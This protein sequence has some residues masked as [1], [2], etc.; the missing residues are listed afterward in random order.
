[1]SQPTITWDIFAEAARSVASKVDAARGARD[2]GAFLSPGDVADLRRMDPDSP[3][4]AFW[5]LMAR[6]VPAELRQGDELERRWA[7]ACRMMAR[8]A[9]H[10]H[11]AAEK[12]G[13]ALSSAGFASDDRPN[14]I[15]R[16]LSAEGTAF[17]DFLASACAFLAAKAS[18]VDWGSLAWLVVH[19][20]ATSRRRLA[21]DFFGVAHRREVV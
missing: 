3:C 12:P 13:S 16:L 14:R 4:S 2:G 18:P 7:V 1:M 20:D 8:M 21:R 10:A 19:Q 11:D 9:P 15:N 17:E 5:R 6:F